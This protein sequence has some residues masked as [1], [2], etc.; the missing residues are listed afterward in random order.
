MANSMAFSLGFMDDE[1]KDEK[2]RF[3]GVVGTA[4]WFA[5]NGNDFLYASANLYGDGR[6]AREVGRKLRASYTKAQ[7]QI[8][9][10][11][12]GKPSGLVDPFNPAQPKGQGGSAFGS[13]S[14]E[15]TA[16]VIDALA[17]YSKSARVRVRSRLVIVEGLIPHGHPETGVFEKFWSAVS[18][19]F[20]IN[21]Y[22]AGG[23]RPGGMGP[24]MG[25]GMGPGMGG[26]MPGG[27]PAPGGV[28]VGPGR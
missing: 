14:S 13:T 24:A 28:P 23:F 20:T 6:T 15:Q 18:G 10:S 8:Y 11:E 3:T 12:S 5:S 9:Q 2:R 27:M 26:G 1:F 21:Q 17:E 22:G 16:D 7:E 25:P 4:S 19:K